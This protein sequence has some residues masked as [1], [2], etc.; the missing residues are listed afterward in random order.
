MYTLIYSSDLAASLTHPHFFPSVSLTHLPALLL[1]SSLLLHLYSGSPFLSFAPFS[2]SLLAFHP[3]PPSIFFALSFLQ[4]HFFSLLPSFFI[5]CFRFNSSLFIF[6]HS[7]S[8]SLFILNIPS[9][10]LS[11]F[12]PFWFGSLKLPLPLPFHSSLFSS[13]LPH[14]PCFFLCLFFCRV[15]IPSTYT[16]ISLHCR[17]SFPSIALLFVLFLSPPARLSH[18]LCSI[19][20]FSSLT[21][22]L[23]CTLLLLLSL[24]PIFPHLFC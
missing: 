19:S 2:L 13:F 1:I 11:L 14:F 12:P 18:S 23:P 4:I 17:F 3:V 8:L 15:S 21:F 7:I 20:F 22:M 5:F 10:S 6:C 24:V 16:H 9:V